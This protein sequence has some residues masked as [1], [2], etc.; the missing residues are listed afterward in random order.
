MDDDASIIAELQRQLR[1]AGAS[2]ESS[3]GEAETAEATVEEYEAEM[4]VLRLDLEAVERE[5]DEAMAERRRLVGARTADADE[6]ASLRAL[7]LLWLDFDGSEMR[8]IQKNTYVGRALAKD[9]RAALAKG[10]G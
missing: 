9:T 6:I 5:R 1:E 10:E 2:I 3:A 7:L 8:T 4:T